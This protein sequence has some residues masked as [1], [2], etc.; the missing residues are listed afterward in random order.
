[1]EVGGFRIFGALSL[2]A[3]FLLLLSRLPY[4]SSYY[5][6]LIVFF[7]IC[8]LTIIFGASPAHYAFQ[9]V[10]STAQLGLSVLAAT[11]LAK[12]FSSWPIKKLKKTFL[13]LASVVIIFAA[14]EVYGGLKPVTDYV[15]KILYSADDVFLYSSD[16]RDQNL[17][18]EI[19]PKIFTQEPS[20]PAKFVAVMLIGWLILSTSRF[21][22]FIFLTLIL[23][24]FYLMRSPSLVIAF[25]LFGY[26]V[27]EKIFTR[28]K[29]IS[30]SV[31]YSYIIFVFL[32]VT[33]V[34]LWVGLLPFSRA[35]SIAEGGDPST[36]IR[37]M[38]PINTTYNILKERP[39]F[40]VGIGASEAADST[41]LDV[42]STFSSIKM[43]RFYLTE[44]AGWG[45]SFFQFFTYFGIVGG[46][47][48]FLWLVRYCQV[49]FKVEHA[50]TLVAFI[51][52]FNA[53]GA[54]VISRPWIYFFII[55]TAFSAKKSVDIKRSPLHR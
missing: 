51:S 14:A 18:G 35:Q 36:I 10:R 6:L 29:F 5:K 30:N 45:N 20:H 33:T 4:N 17:H 41:M 52:I 11:G 16:D 47:L 3:G 13:N 37:L 31:K 40:G 32:T 26:H 39:Y 34:Q 49:Q 22:Y 24:S 44:S 54:F 12:E 43:E 23:I 55:I 42:Y 1:V 2:T 19:R 7:L 8:A 28:Y 46:F 9:G 21:R 48:F 25:V 50:A 27:V 53:E 15:S 38:G